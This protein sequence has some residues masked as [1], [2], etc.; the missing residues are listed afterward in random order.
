MPLTDEAVLAAQ[1]EARTTAIINAVGSVAGDDVR[2]IFTPIGA[3]VGCF[4]AAS[5]KPE[6]AL[7]HIVAVARG[8]MS[9]ELLDPPGEH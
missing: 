4:C 8:V 2:A 3:A 5:E 1:I 6:E 9:G 7:A